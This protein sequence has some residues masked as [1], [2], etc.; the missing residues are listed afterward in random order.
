MS[1]LDEEELKATRRLNGADILDELDEIKANEIIR[2]KEGKLYKIVSCTKDDF[3]CN[4]L[5]KKSN[6]LILLS[7]MEIAK[8]SPNLIDL[9][10]E[11]DYVNGYLVTDKYLF[12]GELPVLE[13]GGLYANAKCLTNKDI[14]TIVTHEQ[15]N[16]VAYKVE[17][18]K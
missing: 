12:N 3:L 2:T 7:D 6:S 18:M 14:R 10:E 4:E 1:E 15:F 17:K 9:I 13:T 5:D 11:G 16:S 8:H